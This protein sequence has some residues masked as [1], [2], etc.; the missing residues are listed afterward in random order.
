MRAIAN[1]LRLK[2]LLRGW[3]TTLEH[4]WNALSYENA[5]LLLR[6]EVSRSG[7]DLSDTDKVTKSADNGA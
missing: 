2:K 6:E 3:G 5:L 4:D 7:G 1:Y